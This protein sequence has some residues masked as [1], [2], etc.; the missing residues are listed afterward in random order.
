MVDKLQ[1]RHER[2]F[3]IGELF[4]LVTA[5]GLAVTVVVQQSGHRELYIGQ[6][7][8]DERPSAVSLTQPEANAVATL[9]MDTHIELEARPDS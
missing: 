3:G 9:L 2:M 4:E 5:S 6:P 8:S 1:V 7:A